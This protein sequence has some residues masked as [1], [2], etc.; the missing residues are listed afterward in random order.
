[1]VAGKG[2]LV[3]TSEQSDVREEL[4]V[5]GAGTFVPPTAR[6][7]RRERRPTGAPPPLPRSIGSSGVLWLAGSVV[8]AAWV[9]VTLRSS[10]ARRVTDQ[11][12]AAILRSIARLRTGW[13]NETFRAIDRAA[14]GWTMFVVGVVLL[15]SI[16]VFRRWRHLFTFLASVL[17]LELL[18][19]LLIEAYSRPRPY[20]VTTIGR[21]TG[22]SLPSAAIAVVSF[23]VVGWIYSMVVPGRP[24]SIA[25]GVGIAVVAVVAFGRL[26]LGVDHPTDVLTGMAIGVAIPLLAFRFFTPNEL[27]PVA[28]R[29]GKTAH[30]DVGG[31]RG[32]AIRRAVE[33]QLGVMVLEAKPVGLAG[34]GGSTPLR[35]RIAG[36]PDTYLFGKLYAM[37]HVRADRW[38]KL[39]RLI[40]Y[41]RLE[42]ERPFQSVRRLVQH[43]DYAMRLLRDAGVP[44]ARAM[45]IVELTPEREY[46]MVAEFFDGAVEIGDAEVDDQIIDEGLALIRQLWN[47]GVAHRDIKPANLLVKDG[48]LHVIDVAFVQVRPSPWREAVDLANMMLVLALRTDAERVYRRALAYFTP[49][50]IAEAFAAAR[51]IAS[52]TQLRTVMKEDGRDLLAQFRALAPQ[53]PP[54]PLQRWGVRRLLLVAALIVGAVLILP[55]IL[56]MF[57]PADL[58][59]ADDPTC[60]TN[61]VMILTAQAVPSATAV[62]CIASFP[63]GWHAS[64]VKVSRG[65]ARFRLETAGHRVEVTLRPPG[66]CAIDDAVEIP[67]DEVGMRRFE[68]PTQLPPDV[69]GTRTYLSAGGCVTYD[70]A[71]DEEADA[72]LVVELDSAL[73]FQPRRE[74][75]AEVDRRSGL[76]LCGADA[77][78]CT[79]GTP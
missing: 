22:Y 38:Y 64:D 68:Q 9:V 69:A 42:D 70:F 18:G 52:P 19:I 3:T 79:G 40:L 7:A 60:G 21:W 55:N 48:H 63:A 46:M 66:G 31:R 49:E 44:T 10:W 47:A 71:F 15:A 59:V 14:T 65:R 61:D 6:Q 12:D 24:R 23:T 13:L 30:L 41:G 25:K 4:H 45:G 73:A 17:V 29:R 16:I 37:N 26:Y 35:L 50:E 11:A 76:T 27:F 8:L 75:V 5:P 62:P 34:S 32:A 58:P 72:S 74:L 57:T 43:E 77:P 28:Y 33:D 56:G 1:V 53:R 78:P 67:S 39:G 2:F 20:D 36:D 54:I 51:G